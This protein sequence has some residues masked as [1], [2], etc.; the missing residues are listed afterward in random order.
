LRPVAI[1]LAALCLVLGCQEYEFDPL[2]PI[3]FRQ[4]VSTRKV[5]AKQ[6]KP[7]VMLVVDRSQSMSFPMTN[8]PQTR[9]DALKSALARYLTDY[10]TV[11]RMGLMTFPTGDACGAGSVVVDLW[12]QNDVP[13]DL[14][15][16]AATINQRIQSTQPGGVTPTG[17]SLRQL[18]SYSGLASGRENV[19]LLVTDGLPNCNP[20]NP[21]SYDV[22]A[23]ACDCTFSAGQCGGQYTRLSC[24]D[25]Q[26]TQTAVRELLAQG[27]KTAVVGIGT[28]MLGG[29]GPQVMNAIASEGGAARSCPGGTDAECGSN[30]RCETQ[31]GVCE[32]RFYRA[33]DEQE[34]AAALATIGYDL[35]KGE[36]CVYQLEVAPSDANYLSVVVDG[37]AVPAGDQTWRYETGSV[38]FVGRLCERLANSTP[39]DPATVEFRVLDTL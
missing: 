3:T 18:A 7:N 16:H 20:N 2:T 34:L 30:N 6:F 26:G 9:W 8:S 35:T 27:I 39:D 36:R 37:A 23:T 22:D 12:T 25:R 11:A 28:D 17:D 13:A 29:T 21:N 15:G 14:Q 4:T 38:T 24:L 31:T 1:R 33:G 5:V 19:I 10:G 32:H